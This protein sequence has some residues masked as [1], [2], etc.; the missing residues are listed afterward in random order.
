MGGRISTHVAAQKSIGAISGVVLLGYPLHPPGRP[1]Q[2]RDAHLPD[3]TE[4]ILFIQGSKDTFGSAQEIRALLPQ[5][6]RATLHEIAGGDHS[7][8]VPG[9]KT[10][11]HE[12]FI[13]VLDT[14]AD[15]MRSVVAA[16]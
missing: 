8:R 7:F 5:L 14:G 10:R 6:E 11:T 2:R 4:P 12:A 3:I 13:E 9:G 1:D 15:W 16:K